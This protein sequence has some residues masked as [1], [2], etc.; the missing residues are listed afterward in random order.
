M[1][2]LLRYFLPKIISAFSIVLLLVFVSAVFS[3]TLLRYAF[4]AGS[5]KL[6]DLIGYAFGALVLL[7]V[8]VAFFKNAH[9]RVDF[10]QAMQKLFDTRFARISSSLAFVIIAILSLPAVGLSWSFLEGS[11]EPNGLGGFFLVKSLLP[12]SFGLIFLFLCFGEKDNKQ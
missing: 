7:S 8:L 11:R 1:A 10:I 4:D 12:I 6:Q 9:V 2:I 3:S 5:V